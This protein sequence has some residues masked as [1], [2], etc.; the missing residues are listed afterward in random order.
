MRYWTISAVLAAAVV[1]AGP[2]HADEP[3]GFYVGAAVGA[4]WQ[5]A[6]LDVITLKGNDTAFKLFGGYR[7][8]QYWALEAAYADLG[9]AQFS[10]SGVEVENDVEVYGGWLVATLP[11]DDRFSL[12]GKVGA[13]WFD[14]VVKVRAF[15]TP[16]GSDREKGTELAGGAGIFFRPAERV[17]LR[18]EYEYSKAEDVRVHVG[19]LGV[20]YTF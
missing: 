18:V 9:D 3:R 13:A 20:S 14:S 16:L 2:V 12:F 17:T 15:G 7:F 11:I 1:S 5:R 8:D 4:N 19:T 6:D 10:E